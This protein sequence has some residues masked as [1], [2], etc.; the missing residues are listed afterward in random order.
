MDAWDKVAGKLAIGSEVT[1]NGELSTDA[2]MNCEAFWGYVIGEGP[3]PASYRIM[4]E[5]G[6][7]HGD[8]QRAN[9]RHRELHERAFISISDDKKHD[10][11]AMQNFTWEEFAVLAKEHFFAKQK[12]TTIC[13]HSGK[14]NFLC[15]VFT[16]LLSVFLSLLSLTQ[17]MPHSILN[18]R[19]LSS[20]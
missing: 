6:I 15:A 9:L 7:E 13:I 4:D 17:T 16:Q 5:F 2:V 8:I 19:P 12:I 1:V 10:S 11:Y 18:P 3:G 14:H 20:G